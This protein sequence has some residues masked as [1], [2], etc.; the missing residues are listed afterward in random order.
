M[1]ITQTAGKMRETGQVHQSDTSDSS[2]QPS[3]CS[4]PSQE[5]NER[6]KET[7]REKGNQLAY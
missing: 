2:A 1:I 5:T 7:Q 6:E 4:P 3:G